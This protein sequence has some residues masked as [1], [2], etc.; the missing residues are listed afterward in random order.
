MM[1]LDGYDVHPGDMDDRDDD[2]DV[3]RGG[4]LLEESD[5]CIP[6]NQDP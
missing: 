1:V 6:F 3:P 4:I 2:E 5:L